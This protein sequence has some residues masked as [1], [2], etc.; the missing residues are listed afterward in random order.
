MAL[1]ERQI[2]S[3]NSLDFKA[4]KEDLKLFLTGQEKFKDYDFEASGMSVL[5]DILAYN[6]HHTAFYTNMLAN[7]SF[8]D[9]ALL[10]SS[11]VS[12][13]KSL[14]YNPRS[15]RGAEILVDVK[16]IDTNGTF[17][18]IIT[19]TNA[20]Q[21]RIGKNEI[22]KCSFNGTYYYFYAVEPKYFAYEGNDSNG[23]PIIYARNVLLREGR[24]KTKT[25]IVNNQFGE[26]QRFIIPDEN[27]DDRS[28]SVFVRKSQ[29]ES[30]GSIDPWIR[31]AN[32]LDNDSTS[33]VFFLQEVY[34]GKYEVYFGDGIVGKPLDQG[35]LILVTYASC[36]G[37]D[38]NNIGREDSAQNEVF[39]YIPSSTQ[40]G[41]LPGVQFNTSIIK[42]S[43]GNPIVSYGGREK[44][45]S[46]SM[47][48]YAPRSYETQ[49]RAVTLNDYITLLQ[50]NY[51]GSIRSIHAW[52][53]EDNTPPEYGKVF[54][55]VRPTLGLFLTTQEKLSIENTILAQKNIVSITPRI[56]D[57]DYLYITPSLKVKYDVRKS[58]KT[59][60]ALETQIVTY[61]RLF[62]LENLSAFEKNFFT[63]SMIKNILDID[64]AIK[65]CT[66]DVEFNKILYPI[67]GRKYYYTVNFNN[68]LTPLSDGQYIQSS[69]FF[70][71][72]NSPNA[73]NLPRVQAYFRDNG[74]GKITLYNN[75]NQ[76]VIKDNF[77][78]VDYTT[79]LLKINSAE[80]LLN[81]NLEKYEVSVSAKPL[82]ED[83]YSSRNT[84]LE[85]NRDQIEVL[86]TPVSTVRI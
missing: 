18:D 1:S 10:R 31:S 19:R 13:S 12:L 77:G 20:K 48:F 33:K 49:D 78:S 9:T 41:S 22:F 44:E 27:L 60:Q 62:G 28:V 63:G 46:V 34:D 86:M 43:S 53:G 25:F 65:S 55:S 83:V 4:I 72:G 50:K 39:S 37:L 29:T 68:A 52:G 47:K 74:G 64:Q 80:F 30:Q 71:Y 38:G 85:M 21:F 14:G 84:I 76:S 5:L 32:I 35:N 51:S 17:P 42:D 45:T 24:I 26:D 3:V 15:R 57:P 61:V 23:N 69:T 67:F 16:M 66:V 56:V 58:A 7:E 2:Q 8:L 73:S 6:T 70:T 81:D 11:N 54:I 36:S 75:S 59:A 40:N 82:D 79:G